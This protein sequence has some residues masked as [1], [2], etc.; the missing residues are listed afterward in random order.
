MAQKKCEAGFSALRSAQAGGEALRTLA[1]DFEAFRECVCGHLRAEEEVG[2]PR[3]R[4]HFTHKD[5]QPVEKKIQERATP[6]ELAWVLRPMASDVARRAWMT[7]VARI[8]GPVQSL[9][10]MPAV[11]KYH[12]DVVVPMAALVEGATE[13][14][15]KPD[16]GCACCVM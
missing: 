5:F 16:A 13:A 2:L 3:M 1:A 11:R 8:P 15:P 14:P 4:H 6:A 10:L 7:D 9:V 12:R